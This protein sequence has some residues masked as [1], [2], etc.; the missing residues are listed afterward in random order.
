MATV[1]PVDVIIGRS[2]RSFRTEKSVSQE[3]LAEALGIT[4]QQIQKYEKAKDRLSVS[5]LIQIADALEVPPNV[6]FDAVL[7]D[8]KSES[9]GQAEN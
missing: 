4:F 7:A 9:L 3:R 2:I 8:I 1:T 6:I 5:R